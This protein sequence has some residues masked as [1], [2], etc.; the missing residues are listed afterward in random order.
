MKTNFH[1]NDFALRLASKSETGADM[2]SEMA[3]QDPLCLGIQTI[4]V[5][6][7]FLEL[8]YSSNDKQLD[9]P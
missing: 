5:P 2:N 8:C 7:C 9:L 4:N 1:K 3:Y 6:K